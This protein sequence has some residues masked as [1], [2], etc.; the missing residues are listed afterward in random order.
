MAA[1][2]T[3]LVQRYEGPDEGGAGEGDECDNPHDS[4]EGELEPHHVPSSGWEW[5]VWILGHP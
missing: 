3:M 5:Q 4:D 2:Q 1:V